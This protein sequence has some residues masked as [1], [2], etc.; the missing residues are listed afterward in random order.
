MTDT[1]ERPKFL[2]S[3]IKAI[4]Q[5][6]EKRGWK[7]LV[8]VWTIVA[9]A[10]GAAAAYFIPVVFWVDRPEIAVAVYIGVLTLNGLVLALSWNAFSRIFE[11]ISSQ[12]FASY[13]MAKGRM[14]GY[15][16][17]VGYVHATQ[18]F[19]VLASAVGL[20]V[21]LFSIPTVLYNQIAFAVMIGASAYAMKTAAGAVTVMHDLIW[22]KAIFDDWSAK[23]PGSRVVHFTRNG[24]QV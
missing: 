1:L 16:V 24:D 5:S 14:N 21:F 15:M 7:A 4:G 6:V 19:A 13:L 2:P 17:F 9:G 11:S 18:L 10:F 23:Q 22:Q 8:P 12:G 3:Y 20:I